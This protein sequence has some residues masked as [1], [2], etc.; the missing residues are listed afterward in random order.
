MTKMMLARPLM[1]NLKI[2]VRDVCTVSACNLPSKKKK[3]LSVKALTPCL[4][5]AGVS[6]GQISA[7]LS[8]QLPASEIKQTFLS[9]NLDCLLAFKRRAVG[10][11]MHTFRQQYQEWKRRYH[12]IPLRRCKN[13]IS[14]LPISDQKLNNLDEMVQFLERHKWS[15]QAQEIYIQNSPG[16]ST[17]WSKACQQKH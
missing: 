1:T 6:L 16:G 7:T 9:T 3:N 2:T 4:P 8:P 15:E 13:N 11:P 14:I 12:V 17:S 10:P 5:G